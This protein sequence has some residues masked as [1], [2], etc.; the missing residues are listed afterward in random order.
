MGTGSPTCGC[1]RLPLANS[2]HRKCTG[3]HRPL[4]AQPVPLKKQVRVGPLHEGR[5]G[6]GFDQDSKREHWNT[7]L[8]YLLK[9]VLRSGNSQAAPTRE[10]FASETPASSAS[11]GQDHRCSS[12][13][14]LRNRAGS[15]KNREPAHYARE[16]GDKLSRKPLGGILK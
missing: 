5:R 12:L 8:E 14:S 16:A 7:I 2:S 6:A 4:V 15:L 3:A 11:R 9:W 10:F 1:S 13:P